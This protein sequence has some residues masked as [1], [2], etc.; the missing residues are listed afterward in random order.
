MAEERE[1]GC[2]HHPV[3]FGGELALED[4]DFREF[5]LPFV[6]L[7]VLDKIRKKWE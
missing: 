3:A 7:G 2:G 6:L 4:V 1:C 5:D